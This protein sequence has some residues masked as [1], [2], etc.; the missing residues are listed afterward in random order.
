MDFRNQTFF[1]LGLS[2]SGYAVVERL[3]SF[4]AKTYFYEEKENAKTEEY[5]KKALEKNAT[6]VFRENVYDVISNTDV[7]VISPGVPINHELA[8]FAKRNGK[9]IIGE[10]EFGLLSISPSLVAVTG[11]NGK[12]TTVT[13]IDHLLKGGDINSVLCGN[14]GLPLTTAIQNYTQESVIVAEVSSF[15]LESCSIYPHVSCILNFTEDHLDRHYSMENYLFLKRRIFKNQRESEYTVL[16]Y[17]DEIV[18]NLEKETRAKVIFVS[19]KEKVDGAYCLNGIIYYKGE[20]ILT[21]K[22]LPLYGLHNLYN[23]L[24]AVAVAKIYGVKTCDILFGIKTFKGVNCIF[25]IPIIFFSF[26]NILVK[27]KFI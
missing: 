15:Q 19:T 3:Y 2:A 8:V 23:V 26:T 16:N 1:I 25:S 5:I 9:L 24:F 6:R 7:F 10:L 17:D 18:R 12:T 13:L 14:V 20:E 22:D 27:S 11:T 4:N 21:E